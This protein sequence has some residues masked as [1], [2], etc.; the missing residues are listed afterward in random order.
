MDNSG[1]INDSNIESA[2]AL[3]PND[4]NLSTTKVNELSKHE[5][6]LEEN[7]RKIKSLDH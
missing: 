3:R 1:I 4:K 2:W 6:G 5:K 7:M